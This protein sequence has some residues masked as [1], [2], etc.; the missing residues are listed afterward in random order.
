[1]HEFGIGE[2]LIRAIVQRVAD[3]GEGRHIARLRLRH[4]IGVHAE[5]LLQAFEVQ[6]RGTSWSTR[7]S[8]SRRT[9]R[10][11]SCSCGHHQS[12]H[13]DDLVGHMFVC[14]ICAKVQP[15]PGCDT[16]D[17]LDVEMAAGAEMPRLSITIEGVV[18]GVGFRPFVYAQAQAHGLSGWVRNG[19]DGVHLE[20]EG[21]AGQ[22]DGFLAALTR[23]PPA[24]RIHRIVT[25]EMTPLGD[26]GWR[27]VRHPREHDRRRRA[28]HAAGRPG[29]VLRLRARDR[30]A[31]GAALPLRVHQLHPVRAAVLDH[32]GTA[33]RPP[34]H[35][36]ARLPLCDACAREYRDPA[37][38]RF[39]AQPIACPDV[40]A[41]ALGLAP[42]AP[43]SRHR[44]TTIPLTGRSGGPG[45]GR[46]VALKGLG[47]FQLLCDATCEEAVAR[48]RAR[49]RR[50]EKPLAVM[51]PSLEA[52][53]A[54]CDVTGEEAAALQSPSAPIVCSCAGVQAHS[55]R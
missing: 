24:A 40:R 41:G 30:D 4:G 9:P 21:A 34:A 36:D 11:C 32:R 39:H 28:T 27:A 47:G 25:R 20:V 48:L 12:V 26:E 7:R 23:P 3:A 51:V 6:A 42:A 16:V 43:T 45:A 31:V 19:G 53:Q 55:T 33:L 46:I 17:V 10:S 18:Q 38:R 22:V 14:P 2:Q 8:C 35:V 49:K 52:L 50:E 13:H 15:V 44:S 1:M 37:D 54:I 5:P 29:D